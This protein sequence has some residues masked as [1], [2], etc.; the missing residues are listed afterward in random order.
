MPLSLNDECWEVIS[1]YLKYINSDDFKEYAVKFAFK[2]RETLIGGYKSGI[3]EI[4]IVKNLVENLD[5][6]K[7]PDN[8]GF[9]IYTKSIFIH[10][11]K[12]YVEFQ[13]KG[14]MV[15][16]ELGDLIFILSVIYKDKKYFE[17]LTISQFKKEYRC[18]WNFNEKQIYLLSHFPAFRGKKGYVPKDKWFHLCNNSGCLGSF[19]LLFEPDG[20]VYMSAE[21]LE[22]FLRNI[23]HLKVSEVLLTYYDRYFCSWYRQLY[24]LT[25]Y[26]NHTILD[27]CHFAHDVLYFT[28]NYL[29][30]N[31]G[32]MTCSCIGNYNKSASEFIRELVKGL[33]KREGKRE[34]AEEFLRYK[35]VF[36]DKN[37]DETPEFDFEDGGI[38]IIWTIIN[39]GE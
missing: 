3:G 39:L 30:G 29:R 25:F 33:K 21:M 32:E 22:Q 38:G 31:I 14:K 7:T 28:D 24:T 4:Y 9:K 13:Y 34:F 18:R 11:S 2:I 27:F 1:R 6:L 36:S 8:K 5:G 17:K 20:F 26:A 15:Y 37:N 12:S 23:K 35:C 16:S 10:G 19:N